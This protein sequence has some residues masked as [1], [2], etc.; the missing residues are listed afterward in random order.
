MVVRNQETE[1]CKQLHKSF[2]EKKITFLQNWHS[3][4][5]MLSENPKLLHLLFFVVICVS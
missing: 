2:K 5:E 3:Y 4:S 1:M